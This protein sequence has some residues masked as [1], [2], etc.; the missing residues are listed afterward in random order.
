MIKD[1]KKYAGTAGWGWARWKGNELK[2]YGKTLTFTQECVN[3][4]QPMK[5]NDF[6]FTPTLAD[7]DRPDKVVSG[8][9]QQ[10]IAT[11]ID[12]RHQ[13]HTALF[14]NSVAVQHARSGATGAYPTG[15][16]L[17]LAT[18]SQ[19]EDKHWFG[20]K[21]PKHLQTVETVKVGTTTTYEGA[22]APSWK[23]LPAADHSDR[24]NYIT[25]LKA[26][27]IFK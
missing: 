6:V 12:N 2:P 26:S 15:A 13:T 5:D 17:T 18:W 1:D 23:Q 27:V 10:L 3:C 11:V 24:I 4:H 20:A 7:A 19:Q 8:A 16:I 21:I 25:H 14:G 22:Q 9:Q